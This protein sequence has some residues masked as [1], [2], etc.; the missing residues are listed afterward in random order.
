[1]DLAPS[2]N[3]M[4]AVLEAS[5]SAEKALPFLEQ[6]LAMRR[7][8]YPESKYPGGHPDLARSLNNLGFVLQASGSAEKPLP[9]F[10]PALAMQRK[11]GQRLLLT[12]SEEVALAYVQAQPRTRDLSLSAAM[13]LPGI[14]AAAYRAVWQSKAAVSRILELRHA[15]ARAGGP[16]AAEALT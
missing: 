11:F 8:L 1:P 15:A 6:A 14:E 4:G 10:E 16:A 12:S 3:N 5:G 7:T 2:L 13:Q 9:F